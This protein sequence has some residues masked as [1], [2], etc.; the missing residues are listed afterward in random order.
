MLV[1]AWCKNKALQYRFIDAFNILY[2]TFLSRLFKTA[3]KSQ[4]CHEGLTHK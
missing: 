3:H 4:Y 2:F 1:S